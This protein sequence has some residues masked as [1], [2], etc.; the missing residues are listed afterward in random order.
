MSH[1]REMPP[2]RFPLV[3]GIETKADPKTVSAPRLLDLQNGI[4]TRALSIAKRRG[5]NALSSDVIGS[6][7]SYP[8]GDGSVGP[9]LVESEASEPGVASASYAG[10][11]GLGARGTELVMFAGNRSFSYLSAL[12]KWSDAGPVYSV[13]QTDRRLL[14]RPTGQ[15]TGDYAV[16]GGVGLVAWMV[17][18]IGPMFALVDDATGRVLL[19]PT[20]AGD[21]AGTRPR[22]VKVGA[23]LALLYVN[24]VGATFAL[25][26]ALLDPQAPDSFDPAVG[27]TVLTPDVDAT[28]PNYDAIDLVRHEGAVVAW[29]AAGVGIRAA[30]LDPSGVLGSP[31]TGWSS[32]ADLAFTDISTPL[33][34]GPVIARASLETD[35]EAIAIAAGATGGNARVYGY[36]VQNKAVI[37]E[38]QSAWVDTAL[39]ET[40]GTLAIAFRVDTDSAGD[41]LPLAV[42]VYAEF[43]DAVVRN[44]LV[45]R[46]GM[47]WF[48]PDWGNYYDAG[49]FFRG[50]VLAS[51]GF[52]VG[53]DSFINLL[54]PLPLFGVYLTCRHDA[55]VVARAFPGTADDPVT[56]RHL[57]RVIASGDVVRWTA[58]A[59]DYLKGI[60]DD[61][62]TDPG[63]RQVSLDFG[64]VSAFQSASAGVSLYLG[65]SAPQIY[66]GQSWVEASFHYGVDWETTET[67][68][69]QADG[70]GAI[71]NGTYNY[72]AV[73]EFTL[74]NGEIL[75]GPASRPLTVVTTGANDTVTINWPTIRLTRM[76]SFGGASKERDDIS[77]AIYRTINGDSSSYY[78]VSSLDTSTVGAMNGYRPNSTSANSVAFIDGMTDA[79]LITQEPAY[80]V[81]GILS[82]D[83]APSSNV[84][85]VAKNRLFTTD[86]SDPLAIHYSQERIDGYAFEAPPEL[87]LSIDPRGGAVTGI[88]ALDD[89]LIVFKASA[90]FALSGPGPQR[91]PD[92]G[93]PEDGFSLP[94]LVT[95]D[96]GCISQRSIANTPA[97]LVFQSAKGI[98]LLDRSRQVSYVGAPVEAYNSQ[99]VTRATLVDDT[100]QIRFLTDAGR[101][102]LYDYLF[103][104]WSTWTNH[105]GLDAVLVGGV[106]HY[107]RTD[108]RVFRESASYADAGDA[109]K[110]RIETSWMRFDEATLQ[111]YSKFWHLHVLGS[112]RSAHKLRVQFALG[113]AGSGDWSDP[114]DLAATSMD[115]TG[116]G[117]GAYGAGVYGGTPNDAYQWRCHLGR[118]GQGIRFAFEDLEADGVHG[119]AFELTE[120][121]V[122]GGTIGPV[123]RP[124]RA[125]RIG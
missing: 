116:Y 85:A 37:N 72:V 6:V 64:D 41:P 16:A 61:Q 5:Y 78:R 38:G 75:R 70:A 39:G 52:N 67:I 26:I 96:V 77:L 114:I 113:Y 22:A 4:F 17:G 84:M 25:K 9:V 94:V 93:G 82:N 110:L 10:I 124:L 54:V 2:I 101:T 90:I 62:F 88:A 21:A 24:E 8:G 87:M 79:V 19:P 115:G 55:L 86:P 91:N 48:A 29:H 11:R 23:K 44:S 76:T 102:L 122:T 56:Y 60:N 112:W 125:S 103:G 65:G 28:N 120:L 97:G 14:D 34:S 1:V 7:S 50:C 111:G 89:A 45:A 33:T 95:S 73:P 81:G 30:F 117:D 100:T 80:F 35:K 69:S 40:V 108:G 83:P 98:Y 36:L 27:V 42:D 106:Y 58:I 59:K 47:T 119:A 31:V 71:P 49:E 57:P 18:G 12:D 99:V 43:R 118:K 15:V 121:L 74:A 63:L 32:A 20:A 105:E 107:A 109:I 13:T 46:S 3:A 51:G 66:D 68:W 104:Q 92:I 123:V 53:K